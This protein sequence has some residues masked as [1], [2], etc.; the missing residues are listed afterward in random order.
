[1]ASHFDNLS[2]VLRQFDFTAGVVVAPD[3][4]IL[5]QA[6]DL[7]KRES[8]DLVSAE[9]GPYGDARATFE[10]LEIQNLPR[11]SGHGEWFAIKHKPA[12]D[13]IVI[14]FGKG[15]S[16]VALYHLSKRV[17]AVVSEKWLTCQ[18]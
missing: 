1:M 3:G 4:S 5:A 10:S 2:T 14:F 8:A 18:L 17:A 12:A 7:A 9:L 11:V 16:S 13:F 6:G 15:L